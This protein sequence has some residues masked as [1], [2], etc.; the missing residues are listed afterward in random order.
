MSLL[1]FD[2]SYNASN[3]AA[4]FLSLTPEANQN[5]VTDRMA[6][7]MITMLTNVT[8]TTGIPL[9]DMETAKSSM[10]MVLV[11]VGII[12]IIALAVAMVLYIRKRKRLEKLRHQLMPMYSFDPGEEQ[13]D[14]EQ[15]LLDHGRDTASQGSQSKI[16]MPSQGSL[17][18]PSRLVFT[19]VANA[20]KA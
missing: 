4:S 8:N 17:Q 16:L 6:L 1:I 7:Q 15:E 9:P 20:I 2:V 11:P 19:D 3:M 12:T 14:L 18:R 10:G 5:N 13:D